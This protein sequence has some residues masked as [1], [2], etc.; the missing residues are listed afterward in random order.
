MRLLLAI[1][2]VGAL[3]ACDLQITNPAPVVAAG[4]TAPS[5]ATT[6]TNTN[7]N[8]STNNNDRSD[9]APVPTTPGTPGDGTGTQALPLPSYG[10]TVTR[11]VAAS[12]PD[13]LRNSCQ[14]TSG[15]SAWG[16]LDTVIRNL[17]AQASDLRWGYLCKDAS[18]SVFA[19]DIVAYRATANE[20]G[21]WIVDVIGGHCP[22]PTDGPPAVRWGVL[23]FE[24]VRKWSA[25]R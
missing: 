8:T 16:F 11:A 5:G 12:N 15:E 21:I 1:V 4:P 2:S 9:T 23:P 3:V 20:T 6:I 18:C 24:T 7:T 17:R 19:R 13:L 22:G 25:S 10:E 14:D